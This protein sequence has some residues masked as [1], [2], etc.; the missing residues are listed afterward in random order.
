MIFPLRKQNRQIL[1]LKQR[2]EMTGRPPKMQTEAAGIQEIPVKKQ[3]NLIRAPETIG[4]RIRMGLK[5][6]RPD[7]R[8]KRMIPLI[9]LRKPAAMTPRMLHRQ[10]K[11]PLN[12]GILPR[13][14]ILPEKRPLRRKPAA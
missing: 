4:P 9:P 5:M 3:R 10:E 2:R 12:P 8:M 14:K 11:K 13:R 1:P 6:I 7:K